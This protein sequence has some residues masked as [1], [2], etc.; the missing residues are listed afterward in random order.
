MLGYTIGNPIDF[1]NDI[2]AKVGIFAI[3][4]IATNSLYFGSF[5]FKCECS[6]A[7]NAPTTPV[8]MAMG[9]ALSLNPS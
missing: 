4:L 3:T 6:N 9:W 7:D 8:N 2:A 1:L 5:K